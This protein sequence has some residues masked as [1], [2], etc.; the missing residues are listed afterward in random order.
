MIEL[1]DT[2][3]NERKVERLLSARGIPFYLERNQQIYAGFKARMTLNVPIDRYEETAAIITLA[4]HESE[5]EV[6][7]GANGLTSY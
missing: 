7:E 1:R 3:E 4:S 5:I 6:V 2:D